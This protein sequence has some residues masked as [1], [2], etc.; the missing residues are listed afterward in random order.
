VTYFI[1]TWVEYTLPGGLFG[2]FIP[3]HLHPIL[4]EARPQIKVHTQRQDAFR[5]VR[6]LGKSAHP[7][8]YWCE[9]LK[10]HEKDIDWS[11]SAN[12]EGE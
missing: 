1:V 6:R 4:G 9:N 2:K 5:H 3:D 11:V 8:L 12:I 7:R 10:Y